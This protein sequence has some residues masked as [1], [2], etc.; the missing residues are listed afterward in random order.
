MAKPI[1]VLLHGAWHSPKCWVNL[2][3]ELDKLGYSAVAPALPSTGST[4][5]ASN[6]HQDID[7]IRKIVSDLI[8]QDRD[9]VLVM[10]SFSGLTGGTAL[11]GLDKQTRQSKGL[12][13]GVVR[14][15]FIAAFLV[16][17]GFQHS[18]RGTADNMLPGMEAD[19]EVR[20]SC[21]PQLPESSCSNTPIF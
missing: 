17:E 21:Y 1:F 19:L 12:E 10:H 9:V 3:T 5:P 6:L 14:L 15:I 13:G 11:D 8:D 7:V 20:S 4:P 2:I 18:P 16:P